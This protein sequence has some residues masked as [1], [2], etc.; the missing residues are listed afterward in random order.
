ML[1]LGVL[2][3]GSG[4]TLENILAEINAGRL[5][6]KVAAVVSSR[7]DAFG[8]ERARMPARA[9]VEPPRHPRPHLPQ[10]PS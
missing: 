10:R 1:S 6:A 3:S 4:R 2:L 7:A 8:I 9:A 5:P